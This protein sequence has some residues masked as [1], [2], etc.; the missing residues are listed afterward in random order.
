MSAGAGV[1]GGCDA[2]RDALADAILAAMRLDRPT[3][4]ITA[5]MVA[6]AALGVVVA[7]DAERQAAITALPSYRSGGLRLI[8]HDRVLAILRGTTDA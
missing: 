2:L 5:G 3:T 8:A 4:A 6:D 7:R 1:G